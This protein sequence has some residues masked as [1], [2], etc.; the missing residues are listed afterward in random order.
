MQ[1]ETG[2]EDEIELEGEE[3]NQSD[4]FQPESLRDLKDYVK[5]IYTFSFTKKKINSNK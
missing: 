4:V 5:R 2:Q 3:K 1:E